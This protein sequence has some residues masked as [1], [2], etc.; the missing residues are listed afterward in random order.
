MSVVCTR[1]AFLCESV[2]SFIEVSLASVRVYILLLPRELSRL[3]IVCHLRE[4]LL[5]RWSFSESFSLGRYY[6]NGVLEIFC[7]LELL[8]MGVM[9]FENRT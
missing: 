6:E 5:W 8:L 2:R 3:F 1:A 7:L 9:R 4:S